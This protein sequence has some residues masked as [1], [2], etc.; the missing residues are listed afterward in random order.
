[1]RNEIFSEDIRKYPPFC[2]LILN[3][4]NQWRNQSFESGWKT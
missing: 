3:S 4:Y 1:M 2:N